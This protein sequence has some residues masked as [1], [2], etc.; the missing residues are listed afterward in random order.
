M[1]FILIIG[2]FQYLKPIFIAIAICLCLPYII[3]IAF[4]MNHMDLEPA[5]QVI[6]DNLVV[7]SY[8]ELKS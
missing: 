3:F 7:K 2:Y 5:E 1:F 8:G 6:L 4:R